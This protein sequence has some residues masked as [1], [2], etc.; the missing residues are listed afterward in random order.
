[1]FCR[2]LFVLLYFFLLA[3]VL[4]V[5]RF[6]D[7]DCLFGIFKLF[8]SYMNNYFACHIWISWSFIT[9]RICI[10]FRDPVI[11]G[12][13]IRI[14]STDLTPPHVLP[15]PSHD[16]DFQSWW[17]FVPF[18]WTIVLSVL[19]FSASD[20]TFDIFKLFWNYWKVKKKSDPAV[21]NEKF[22][23]HF[24]IPSPP[25]INDKKKSYAL[26]ENNF[27]A[28]GRNTKPQQAK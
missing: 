18:L 4:S 20:Y 2:S 16:L 10:V 7:S 28:T 3:I 6:T 27:M 17:L 23:V 15:V 14:S 8:L 19:W 11:K 1:M 5:L 9:Y 12:G 26:R 21:F 13:G 25:N 24:V 22:P